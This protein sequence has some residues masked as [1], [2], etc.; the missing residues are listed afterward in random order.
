[1]DRRA[2]LKTFLF[3]TTAIA[4]NAA[5]GGLLET[6]ALADGRK[7]A[8]AKAVVLGDP[9]LCSGCR[10]CEVVCSNFNSQGK[11]SSSLSRLLVQK[12]PFKGDYR[13]K[14][15]YQCSEPP[16]LEACPT[17]ALQIDSINRTYARVI[18]QR[19]CIGCQKCLA[20]CG[21]YFDPPRPRFEAE[22]QKVIKCH[23][24]LGDPQCVKFCP[25]GALRLE[26]SETGLMIG[27]PIQREI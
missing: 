22:N 19:A 20:A 17:G 27:Y 13:P 26:R 24:C 2:A 12:D 11:N 8:L 1:M 18:D 16:C 7:V 9:N 21:D 23:L 15:C 5:S 4:G 10:T 14:T 6:L 3:G 25:L